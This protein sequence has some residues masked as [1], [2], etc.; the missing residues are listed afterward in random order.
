MHAGAQDSLIKSRWW[1]MVDGSGGCPMNLSLGVVPDT[2][3]YSNCV[4]AAW[5]ASN[6]LLGFLFCQEQ[7]VQLV[8]QM[9]AATRQVLCRPYA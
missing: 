2:K 4:R 1:V 9:P 5:A 3:V 6:S 8:V 7:T